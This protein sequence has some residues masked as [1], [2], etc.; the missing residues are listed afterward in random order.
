MLASTQMDGCDSSLLI[1]FLKAPRVGLV[2]T[3]LAVA[4]GADA[5]CLAYRR[6]VETLLERLTELDC[7][8][9]R[10]TPDEAATEMERWRRGSW[11]LARQGSGDLGARLQQAFHEAFAAGW[12]RV[13]IIGSDCPYILASDIK[14][15]WALLE[16][17]EVVLGPA[18][19]GGYWLVGLRTERRELF[20][21]IP[22]STDAVFEQTLKRCRLGG[23]SV[24]S[25]R[26]LID[27]DT[28]EQWQAFMEND[29][30]VD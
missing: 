13:V 20:D 29:Q 11:T 24:Q 6:L 17:T 25:L 1:I 23:W 28:I 30:E 15:A 19:D 14:M 3:R 27:V 18:Q 16:K 12:K 26:E 5:A 2:K 8:Q 22:W 10:F 9:L 21:G 7:I 4:L